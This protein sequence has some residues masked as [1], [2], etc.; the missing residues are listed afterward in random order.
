MLRSIQF[1]LDL[2]PRQKVTG[3][4]RR[5]AAHLFLKVPRYPKKAIAIIGRGG[6]KSDRVFGLTVCDGFHALNDAGTPCDPL[7]P[8]P[9]VR[10][11]IRGKAMPLQI[12]AP[13][14][15]CDIGDRVVVSA[16]VAGLCQPLVEEAVEALC[17]AVV[18]G[19]SI[20]TCFL[21]RKLT[22]GKRSARCDSSPHE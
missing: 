10:E 3:G 22:I 14:I 16:Q 13:R 2:R 9:K 19:E 20:C 11:L 21:Y 6:F 12:E 18:T 1:I 4:E 15:G 5:T 8:C 17:F 7:L